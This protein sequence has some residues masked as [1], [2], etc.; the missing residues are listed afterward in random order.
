M[1]ADSDNITSFKISEQKRSNWKCHLFGS[2]GDGIT[3]IPG[4]GRVPNFIVRWFM[5]I[6]L[7]CTWVKDKENE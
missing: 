4:E 1:Q 3:Y 6:C 2:N 7:G 5:K